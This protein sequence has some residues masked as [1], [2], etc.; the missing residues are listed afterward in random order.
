[1][2]SAK[3]PK[4]LQEFRVRADGYGRFD[5]CDGSPSTA[6]NFRQLS[7]REQEIAPESPPLFGSPLSFLNLLS[8]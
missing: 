2:F 4:P 5:I 7:L 3:F 6:E 1:M 8:R